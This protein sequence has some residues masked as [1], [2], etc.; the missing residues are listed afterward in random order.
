MD[1]FLPNNGSFLSNSR[2]PSHLD[3]SAM[4]SGNQSNSQLK[5]KIKSVV[6]RVRH[7]DVIHAL[8]ESKVSKSFVDERVHEIISEEFD[9]AADWPPNSATAA[10]FGKNADVERLER[11]LMDYKN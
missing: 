8:D 1:S 2:F 6:N 10:S 4:S 5:D 9:T 7:D 3:F 11:E